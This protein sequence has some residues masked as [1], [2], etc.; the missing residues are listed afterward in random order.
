MRIAPGTIEHPQAVNAQGLRAELAQF[1][2]DMRAIRTAS[3]IGRRFFHALGVGTRDGNSSIPF[4]INPAS[5]EAAYQGR[6]TDNPDGSV[7][8]IGEHVEVGRNP[9]TGTSWAR[10]PDI[11]VHERGHAVNEHIVHGIG[12]TPLSKIVDESL[13]D[14]WAAAADGNW[15][16]GEGILPG[17]LR[18][19]ADP[20]RRRVLLHDGDGSEKIGWSKVASRLD[21]ID[22]ATHEDPYANIGPLNNAAYRI[23][24]T[25]GTR[26][27][28][29][30]YLHTLRHHLTPASGPTELLVGTIRSAGE[31]HGDGSR[32]QQAVRD[33]WK[34]VGAPAAAVDAVR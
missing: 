33:A 26:P 22:T 21:E 18:S 9:Y 2:D 25:I 23:G 7:N 16:I 3:N 27:M 6:T 34:A 17:G 30:L 19:M 28:A 4:R 13:A 8:Y 10:S 29:E 5:I 14:T 12:Q 20:G 31:L 11:L 32:E 1:E 15:T 24:T